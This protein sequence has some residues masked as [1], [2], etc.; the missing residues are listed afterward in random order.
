MPADTKALQ[1]EGLRAG[2][3]KLEILLGT[4]LAVGPGEFISLMGP[5]G[6]G[7]STLLKTIFGMT[8]IT[9]GSVSWNGERISGLRPR[10]IL[11]RGVAYVP[12]GRCNF[13]LMSVDENLDMASFAFPGGKRGDRDFVFDLFPILRDRRRHPA[14]YLSG[15]EQQML[16]MGMAML[17]RPRLLLIDEPSVGLAPQAIQQVFAEI[18]RI[19]A[20]GCTV[21]LVEQNTRKAMEVS[22]RVAVL[23]LGQVIWTGPPAAITHAQLGSLFMT[24]RLD[25]APGT[26]APPTV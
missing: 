17:L 10:D 24:G 13:P 25:M 3:G 1:V 9:A 12:Q 18:L 4:D 2:Y 22:G 19:N 6:A 26:S 20:G 8:A 23:R 14:G 15:G 21:V 11:R 7:K 16:E 5:N